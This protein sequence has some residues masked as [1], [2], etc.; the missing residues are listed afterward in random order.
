M[1]KTIIPFK[2]R[3]RQDSG[4]RFPAYTKVQVVEKLVGQSARIITTENGTI[5]IVDTNRTDKIMAIVE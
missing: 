1:P 3:L 4:E 2:L 5:M